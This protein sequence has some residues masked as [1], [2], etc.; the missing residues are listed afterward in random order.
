MAPQ[1]LQAGRMIGNHGHPGPLSLQ[2]PVVNLQPG[3][4][5]PET[6][7]VSGH[8]RGHFF[9]SVILSSYISSSSSFFLSSS[10]SRIVIFSEQLV[11]IHSV[12]LCSV[13]V[14]ADARPPQTLCLPSLLGFKLQAAPKLYYL[15]H[16]TTRSVTRQS[17]HDDRNT[18]TTIQDIS[19]SSIP[20][21]NNFDFARGAAGCT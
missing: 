20:E 10:L 9:T 15:R 18:Y 3:T 4:V 13:C 16:A 21:R 6:R 2:L 17:D 14:R 19:R 5:H 7:S 11:C 1:A 12:V 8:W